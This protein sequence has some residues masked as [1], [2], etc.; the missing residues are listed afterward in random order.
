MVVGHDGTLFHVLL[1]LFFP[2]S[3]AAFERESPPLLALSG[4]V[5]G[6]VCLVR[7]APEQRE[8][9][10]EGSEPGRNEDV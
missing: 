3:F 1:V 5:F 7:P 8:A 9:V 10:K 6:S 4:L 2:G